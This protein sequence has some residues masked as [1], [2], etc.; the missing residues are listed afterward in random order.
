MT[1]AD[2]SDSLTGDSDGAGGDGP[3]SDVEVEPSLN[4]RLTDWL[5]QPRWVFRFLLL[6]IAVTFTAMVF[7]W[8]FV[9]LEDFLSILLT[10]LFLSVALDPASIRL[11]RRRLILGQGASVVFLVFDVCIYGFIPFVIVLM[12]F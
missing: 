10:S 9:R 4:V 11:Y 6:V 3:A 5:R 7:V 2:A 8:A 1:A 12:W